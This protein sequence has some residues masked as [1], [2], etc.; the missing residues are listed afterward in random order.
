MLRC[1]R[2]LP[3]LESLSVTLQVWS[4]QDGVCRI[5]QEKGEKHDLGV[6]CE[7][8]GP[9]STKFWSFGQWHDMTDA[10]SLAL[11]HQKCLEKWLDSRASASGR[12]EICLAEYS[13]EDSWWA[14]R[15]PMLVTVTECH[16]SRFFR[17]L[18]RKTPIGSCCSCA[19]CA[20]GSHSKALGC[21]IATNAVDSCLWTWLK[22]KNKKSSFYHRITIC[23][24]PLLK[25]DT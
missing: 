16:R 3:S 12:C 20:S 2:H 25:E 14:S 21:K 6:F 9:W 10:G 18:L 17:M 22:F 5:C 7:C 19:V 11:C 15:W 13:V 1:E 4:C 23:I 24:T 8:R